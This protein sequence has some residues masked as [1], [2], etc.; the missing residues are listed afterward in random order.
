MQELPLSLQNKLQNRQSENSL[1]G[2]HVVDP[3][4]VDFFSNDYLGFAN[5]IEIQNRALELMKGVTC[6]N[7]STGS[8]LISGTH[9]LHVQAEAMLASFHQSKS[10]L[11][12]NSGYD[13]NVGL[14][15]SI[16]QKGDVLFY[17]E[18]LHASCRDGIRLSNAK[19]YKFKHN[20][21]VD[22]EKRIIRL[23]NNYKSI[24]VAVESI[25]SMDGDTA[26]LKDLV[27]LSKKYNIRLIVDEAHSTGVY[28]DNG[29]GLIVSLGLQNDIFARVHTF[30]KALGCHGAAVL[31]GSEL[32]EY[33]IN[34][35]RSFI[36]TTALPCHAVATIIASYIE[37]KKGKVTQL[38][39]D[40]IFLFKTLIK[41]KQIDHL[42]IESNS[43]IQCCVIRGNNRVKSIEQKLIENH[44]NV[45]AVLSPTVAKG[46]ER[47]RVCVHLFNTSNEICKFLDNLI[48]LLP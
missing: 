32:K 46:E 33:L 48:P 43:A 12:Y 41:Q 27:E 26:P 23:N 42:F 6:V 5:S 40:K 11:L 3:S 34:F 35:S 7:G 8:R 22:L 19:S 45:K 44:F 47:I 28:G 17:D 38:L 2:I 13:A 9:S 4:G 39:N 25:Y 1:R 21:L 20:S 36:Y 30:G 15:S 37:L 14:F 24:Y 10:A 29:Q 16:L 18:L 31:G